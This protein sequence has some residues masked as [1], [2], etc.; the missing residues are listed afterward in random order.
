MDAKAA[1]RAAALDRRA[2][3]TSTERYAAGESIADALRDL[4]TK[5]TRVAAYVAI[6]TEPSTASAV[7]PLREVML[8]ILLPDND[9]DWGV[10]A[11]GAPS[12]RGLIEP[13]GPR[14]GVDAIADCDVVLVPALAVDHA[15]NRLGRGGGS[16]DRALR[17]ATGLT[18]AVLYD[19]ELV[20]AVPTEPHDVRVGAVVTPAG[21]VL[22]G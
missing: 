4:L 7:A 19:D 14:L 2:E 1:L 13:V 5:A 21:L 15:G 18:V 9:L 8:P 22:L 11:V 17:R 16:Y 3:R 10:G 20:D 12:T 6:G